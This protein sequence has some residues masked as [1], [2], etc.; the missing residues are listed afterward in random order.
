[1]SKYRL[2]TGNLDWVDE[3][4]R[5]SGVTAYAVGSVE[6]W[7]SLSDENRAK[8]NGG[9]LGSVFECSFSGG[10]Y[11]QISNIQGSSTLTGFNGQY[12]GH[13]FRIG[14]V[15]NQ[16]FAG[17]IAREVVVLGASVV[18][19]SDYSCILGA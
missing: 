16:I 8:F 15:T 17:G 11:H 5:P 18:A 2:R 7:D 13:F 9:R 4:A 3:Y 14:N 1:M 19:T 12:W 6:A 10:H